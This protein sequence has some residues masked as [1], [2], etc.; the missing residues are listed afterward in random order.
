MNC[1]TPTVPCPDT[2]TVWFAYDAD[3]RLTRICPG[4][5]VPASTADGGALTSER[6]LFTPLGLDAVW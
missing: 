5:A 6:I 2:Q 3:G 4:D 1:S